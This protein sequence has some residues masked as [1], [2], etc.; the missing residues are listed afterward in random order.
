MLNKK[1]PLR[2]QG[3][4]ETAQTKQLIPTENQEAEA[5]ADYLRAK[6]L[7]FTHIVNEAQTKSWG[8]IMRAK[9]MGKAR[10]V[11]DYMILVNNRIVFVE[12]KRQKGS[13]V[14]PEQQEWIEQLRQC[15]AVAEICRGANEAIKL[16]ESIKK[17]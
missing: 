6:R 5:F 15:G 17:Q 10:G 14:S 2:R 7:T 11:P 1:S 12:L 13:V 9:R 3:K 16:I 4:S 8:A